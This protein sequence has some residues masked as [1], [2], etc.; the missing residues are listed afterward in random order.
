MN[1][2][3]WV[4]RA[5]TVLVVG[6]GVAFLAL[7][8]QR[9]WAEIGGYDWQARWGRIAVSVALLSASLIW[10]AYVWHRVLARFEGAG[11]RFRR[12][13]RISFVSK[14]A[15]YIPG[16]V[17]QFVAVGQLSRGTGSS[18]G[19]LVSS[20]LVHAGFVFLSAVI[21]ASVVLAERIDALPSDPTTAVVGLTILCVALSHPRLIDLCLR[22][23]ARLSGQ[24]TIRW[25]GGWL[26]SLET[27]FFSLLSWIADGVAFYLFVGALVHVD[28]QQL[29]ALIGIHAFSFVVGY[30]AF[31]APAGAG[32]REATMATL[33]AGLLPSGAA[34][35]VA[36]LARLWT[37]AAELVG[38]IIA[39]V[40]AARLP[41]G[42]A[43][44]AALPRHP[45]E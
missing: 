2:R 6:A 20:L 18:A 1:V 37:I 16:K 32:V 44:G 30:I 5:A 33:L 45:V 23:A 7:T 39:L 8:I 41:G 27:L 29:L 40:L 42:D 9:N 10:S 22:L 31:V 35:V 11:I 17:W 24:G 43:A 15:R 38:L 12:L 4:R 21:T 19:V 34:A 36:I 14:I 13:L 26:A 28:P 3:R 25:T